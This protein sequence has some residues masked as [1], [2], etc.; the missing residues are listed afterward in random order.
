MW[1]RWRR[2][3]RRGRHQPDRYRAGGRQGAHA[4]ACRGGRRTT[5]P[6]ASRRDP[7]AA[8]RIGAYA[9]PARAARIL[10]G[11]GF[12]EAEQQ[13]PCSRI[14]RRLAHARRARGAA[15]L[16]ARSSAAGRT[17]ELSRSRRR[18]VARGFPQALSRH[19]P[20]GEPRPRSAEPRGGFHPASRAQQADALH[21]RLRHVRRDARDE[22]RARG[23]AAHAAGSGAQAHP[24]LRRPLPLQGVEGAPGAEPHQVARNDEADRRRDRR[25]V[26]RRSALPQPS[27]APPLVALDRVPVGYAPGKPVLSYLHPA[28][29]SRRPH[30]AAGKQRQRQVH[31]GEAVGSGR[32]APMSG[33]MARARKLRSAIS[34]STSSTSWRRSARRA[35]AGRAP[36]ASRR[37]AGARA[38]RRVRLLGREGGDADRAIVRRRTGAAAARASRRWTSPIF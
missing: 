15:V 6:R 16:G 23:G 24:G 19:G 27:R 17:D 14:L 36:P 30:R 34:R 5:I 18:A 8:R 7:C 13:R 4:L 11:L 31:P 22:A 28:H 3:R 10:A 26:W 38:A 25:A 32:L 35:D 37:N 29:R 21:R 9:A 33:E 20:S 12:G 2:K 1:A